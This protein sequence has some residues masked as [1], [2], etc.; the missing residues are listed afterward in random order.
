MYAG[1]QMAPLIKNQLI[2]HLGIMKQPE[3]SSKSDGIPQIN[4]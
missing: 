2:G 1:M 4:K 3:L